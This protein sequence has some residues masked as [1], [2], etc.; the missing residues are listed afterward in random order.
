[1]NN[2]LENPMV[3]G[4]QQDFDATFKD[5]PEE[6]VTC[7]HCGAVW[8]KRTIEPD[9]RFPFALYDWE[10]RNKGKYINCSTRDSSKIP[11]TKEFCY[12]CAYETATH[13]DLKDF[14]EDT[15]CGTDDFRE[16][17]IGF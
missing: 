1:M 16:W 7:P 12:A 13:E 10:S 8:E 17:R 5:A 2:Q 6:T 15:R 14:I 4:A 11:V 9:K 3:V